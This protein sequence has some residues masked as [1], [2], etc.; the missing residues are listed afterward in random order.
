MLRWRP[1]VSLIGWLIPHKRRGG[2]G[3]PDGSG[4]PTA[5]R[6]GGHT[7]LPFVCSI[8]PRSQARNVEHLQ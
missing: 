3:G 2:E 1:P 8:S 7:A 4:D 5:R 6:M